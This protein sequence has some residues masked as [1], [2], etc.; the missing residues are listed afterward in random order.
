MKPKTNRTELFLYT[1]VLVLHLFPVVYMSP[2]VTLDGPAH[3]YN[4][5][6]MKS[7]LSSE[8]TRVHHFFEFNQ[9]PHP[10]WSGHFLLL[11]LL[12]VVPPLMAEKILLLLLIV[13][14]ATG[15]RK[16]IKTV[17]PSAVWLSWMYFPFLMSFPFLLGFYNFSFAL[18][19]LPW[20]LS[21]WLKNQNK[22]KSLK[23]T[24]Q[25]ILFLILLYFSHLVIFLLAGLF[26]GIISLMIRD[27]DQKITLFNKI[28]YLFICSLPGIVLTILFLNSS[29][30]EGYRGEISRL[31][32]AQLF[33]DILYSR[34]FI[35][36]DYTSEK[37]ITIL[38]TA[39]MV[40]LTITGFIYRT[41]HKL[42]G[43][44]TTILLISL[45]L[46]FIMPDSMASGG[47]L[48]VRL[49]Q[50]F[51]TA[52]ILWLATLRLPYKIQVAGAA[53]TTL[54][55]STMLT[56]HYRVQ[57]ELNQSAREFITFS[58]QLEENKVLLPLN[59]SANWMHSNLSCYLGTAKNIVVLDNYEATHDLFPL[60]WRA[61]MDPE[62]HMGNHVS[63][64]HPCVQ[65]LKSES[66][67]KVQ[68]DYISKWQSP[69]EYKD[70]CDLS[71]REQINN[72]YKVRGVL[73]EKGLTLYG[74]ITNDQ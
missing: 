62:I 34:M 26:A 59:Y 61:G 4:A 1:L 65:I 22:S 70:S 63:S 40:F 68:V 23:L 29:G 27:T 36:Y 57:L 3:L 72:Y 16:L 51:F 11:I 66:A 13:V 43:I 15:F 37:K 5:Q 55:S 30:T 38:F 7:L 6:L 50:L 74:R 48:S 14:S 2:F 49:V 20:W 32:V 25:V 42:T 53:I 12:Y 60:K 18:A 17:E 64:N 71:V 54:F 33:N 21:L 24:C 46:I 58:N 39:L 10:N 28:S 31:P 45:A 41:I 52:W 47:I 9:F 67:T 8:N 73:N 35:A 56:Y 44:F 69:G 19:L